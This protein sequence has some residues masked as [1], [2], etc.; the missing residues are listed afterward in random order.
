MLMLAKISLTEI[1]V[2]RENPYNLVV[3]VPS[4][5]M[6]RDRNRERPLAVTADATTTIAADRLRLTVATRIFLRLP[7]TSNLQQQMLQE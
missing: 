6:L 1:A 7:Q 4:S 2:F 5:F 3:R